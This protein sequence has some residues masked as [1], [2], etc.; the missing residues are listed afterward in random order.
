MIS[1][2]AAGKGGDAE[3]EMGVMEEEKI[4]ADGGSSG[5]SLTESMGGN[6]RATSGS[7]ASSWHSVFSNSQ[8]TSIARGAANPLLAF[9]D[10]GMNDEAFDFAGKSGLGEDPETGFYNEF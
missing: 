4:A 7:A 1:H 2:A 5:A 3:V 8:P 9:D 6:S 10:N